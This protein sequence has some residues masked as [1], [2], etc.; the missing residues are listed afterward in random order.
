MLG[1]LHAD[2]FPTNSL[3]RQQKEREQKMRRSKNEDDGDCDQFILQT[4]HNSLL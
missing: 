4:S 3:P 2:A 1:V